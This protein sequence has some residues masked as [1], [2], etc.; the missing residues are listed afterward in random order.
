MA[1]IGTQDNFCM[2]KITEK[3]IFLILIGFKD[4]SKTIKLFY[5]T[6]THETQR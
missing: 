2:F 6:H 1:K 4:Y 3:K 5:F